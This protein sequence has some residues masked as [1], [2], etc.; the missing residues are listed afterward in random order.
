M[1]RI[2]ALHVLGGVGADEPNHALILQQTFATRKLLFSK[3][4]ETVAKLT[5]YATSRFLIE[6]WSFLFDVHRTAC[7][8]SH[9]YNSMGEA[10]AAG[11]TTK[12]VS[13]YTKAHTRVIKVKGATKVVGV[14]P[15]WNKLKGGLKAKKR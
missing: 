13:S 8:E 2:K 7:Y 11:R 12:K 6:A 3:G 14:K 1:Q 5:L 4:C 10:M 9:D 15:R